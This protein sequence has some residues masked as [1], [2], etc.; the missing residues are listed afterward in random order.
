MTGVDFRRLALT[1]LLCL[2]LSWLSWADSPN[3]GQLAEGQPAGKA[4]LEDLAWLEGRWLGTG[5]GDL[6]EEHWQPARAGS[7][8][9]LFRQHKDGKPLF[10]EFM[11]LAQVGDTVEMRIKHFDADLTGW[12]EK[13]EFLTFPLI[14]VKPNEARFSGLTLRREGD[15]LTIYLAMRHDDKISEAVFS[16]HRQ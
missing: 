4:R 15:R 5:F 7:M 10:Y 1:L 12:E 2:L 16:L 13:D 3:T 8:L 9:G 11:Q 14:E 6:S